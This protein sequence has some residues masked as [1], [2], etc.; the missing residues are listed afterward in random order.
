[1]TIIASGGLLAF[2]LL[3]RWSSNENRRLEK[4]EAD[5]IR[6][7]ESNIRKLES[8]INGHDDYID[9]TNGVIGK[10][11]VDLAVQESSMKDLKA[12]IAEIKRDLS[13]I[14]TDIK[15]LLTR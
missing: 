12:D 10:I 9:T 6:R 14:N 15:T 8:A 5:D 11:H 4:Q 13:E 2:T 1:L 3:F 7:V